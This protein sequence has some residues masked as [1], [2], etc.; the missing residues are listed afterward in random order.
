MTDTDP[1]PRERQAELEAEAD[2]RSDAPAESREDATSEPGT[3]QSRQRRDLQPETDAERLADELGRTDLRTTDE[4]YV[5]ARVVDI[6]DHDEDQIELTVRLPTGEEPRF[7]L[8]KPLPWSD[9]FLFARIVEEA[10]YDAASVEHL[11]DE[12]VLV[13]RVDQPDDRSP[14]SVGSGSTPLGLLQT[15]F[16]LSTPTADGTEREWRLVDPD[17]RTETT[18]DSR[19]AGRSLFLATALTALS[20]VGIVL[21]SL[22]AVAVLDL[23]VFVV[24]LGAI[25]SFVLVG[26]GFLGYAL[27]VV[28][29]RFAS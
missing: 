3:G 2:E 16:G 23:S 17:E 25:A 5:R 13:E 29:D 14:T 24:L 19:S 9:T 12:S 28:L 7:R 20:L 1:D 8:E 18:S 6:T 4:G 26:V 11:V 27:S 15:L 22:L 10:G 21:A